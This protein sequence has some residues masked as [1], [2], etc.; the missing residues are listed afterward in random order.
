MSTQA[1]P[2]SWVGTLAMFGAMSLL[3][4]VVAYFLY[5]GDDDEGDDAA[6]NGD[7]TPATLTLGV[8]DPERPEVGEVAP[9]FALLD[10]RDGETVRKLSDYR[11]KVVVLNWYATWCGPCRSEIPEFQEA[12]DALPQDVVFLLVNL[13]EPQDR[14]AGFLEELDATM[15]SVLDSE[16]EVAEHYRVTG[17]PTTYFIDREGKVTVSGRGLVTEEALREELGKLGL[18]Y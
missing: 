6:A 4:L 12:Q 17:M 15:V 1:N 7:G 9:D 18:E 10:T 11:G 3:A 5:S 2:R 8:L 14:A 13:E 16:G